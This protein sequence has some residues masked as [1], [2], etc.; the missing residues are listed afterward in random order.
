VSPTR[1][2]FDPTTRDRRRK[3]REA[4]GPPD[5]GERR[6]ADDNA[7]A[8]VRPT[9]A[10]EPDAPVTGDA[11]GVEATVRRFGHEARARNLP[12]IEAMVQ[13]KALLQ[14]RF[15]GPGSDARDIRRVRR[16]FVEAYYF[17]RN[18]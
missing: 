18:G 9:L 15:A 12:A 17:E 8:E 1:H 14:D 6:R 16:W 3:E 10:E 7:P 2:P 4:A 5:T 13:L 11:E